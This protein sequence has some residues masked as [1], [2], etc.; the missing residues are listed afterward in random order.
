MKYIFVTIDEF[1]AN[2]GKIEIG[3]SIYNKD[4][5]EVGEVKQLLDNGLT[6]INTYNRSFQIINT[7]FYVKIQVQP[8]Y[9]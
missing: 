8:I 6:I 1:L 2:N 4:G 5:L 9:V 3:R 7:I